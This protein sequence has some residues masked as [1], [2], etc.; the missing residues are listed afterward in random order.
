MSDSRGER[1][2]ELPGAAVAART[3]EMDRCERGDG[4]ADAGDA[5][6]DPTGFGSGGSSSKPSLWRCKFS[7]SLSK[8]IM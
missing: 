7:F 8:Y 1:G 4:G 3:G 5:G 6:G 2:V